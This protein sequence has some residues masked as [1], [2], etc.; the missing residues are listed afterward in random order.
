MMLDT[1]PKIEFMT[2]YIG[3]ICKCRHVRP[4]IGTLPQCRIL[5]G[6]YWSICRM[7]VSVLCFNNY[8][9]MKN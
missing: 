7:N 6:L 2:G 3:H 4:T 1:V 9:M 5:N 8:R